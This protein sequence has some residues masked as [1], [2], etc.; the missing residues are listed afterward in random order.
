[1]SIR[2]KIETIVLEVLSGPGRSSRF[3]EQ[4]IARAGIEP[5]MK[6]LDMA[7]AVGGMAFAAREK[8]DRVT[9]I[10]ISEERIKRARD[11]LRADGIN[12]MVMS[13]THTSFS[14]KEFDVTLI[15]LGLHEMTVEE[16]RKALKEARRI[17]KR[18]VVMEFGI[19]QWPLFWRLF[20]YPLAAFE[21]RVFFDFTRQN[22]NAMIKGS[23]WIIAKETASF[24][25]VTYICAAPNR[26]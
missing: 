1:M 4:I 5:G 9:A 17:S 24:P 15:V 26:E 10:D 20:R 19:S 25:F 3:R 21:P 12:F 22:V 16:A 13:A 8:T 6:V 11:D 18:L 14:D 23:G 7:T 2:E